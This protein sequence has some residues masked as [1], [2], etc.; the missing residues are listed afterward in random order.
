MSTSLKVKLKHCAAPESWSKYTTKAHNFEYH[1]LA[2]KKEGIEGLAC[3]KV[4]FR[5]IVL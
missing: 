2:T 5:K 3:V 4:P 1:K